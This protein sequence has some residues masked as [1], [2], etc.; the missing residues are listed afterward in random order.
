MKLEDTTAFH[1]LSNQD[2][3]FLQQAKR[4]I[5]ITGADG[6]PAGRRH[7]YICPK[8]GNGSGR[9]G[10]GMAPHDC[11]GHERWHCFKCGYDADIIGLY[12]D[13]IGES[14][15]LKA[16]RKL[17]DAYGIQVDADWH[18]GQKHER[19]PLDWDAEIGGGESGSCGNSAGQDEH[20]HGNGT[21][22]HS[23][24]NGTSTSTEGGQP[25]TSPAGA[26]SPAAAPDYSA[27]YADCASH[28]AE[29]SYLQSRGIS[30]PTARRLGVGYDPHCTSVPGI[31]GRPAIIFPASRSVMSARICDLNMNSHQGSRKKGSPDVSFN[32]QALQDAMIGGGAVWITEGEID[33]MS[34]EELGHHAVGIKGTPRAPAFLQELF[35]S[36]IRMP[37]IIATDDDDPGR[38]AAGVLAEGLARAQIP[39]Y[40][41]P[42]GWSNGAK[43]PNGMLTADRDALAEL[44]DDAEREARD[45]AAK[46]HA[47]QDQEQAQKA[48]DDAAKADEAK[49]QQEQEQANAIAEEEKRRQRHLA[50]P[51]AYR[52]K[53]EAIRSDRTPRIAT[54]FKILDEVLDGGLKP[55]SLYTVGAIS[56]LGKTTFCTQIGDYIAEHGTDVLIFSLEMARSELISKSVSRLTARIQQQGNPRACFYSIPAT[57]CAEWSN[58]QSYIMKQAKDQKRNPDDVAREVNSL[59]ARAEDA[60]WNPSAGAA[61]RTWIY[62]SSGDATVDD[63][64]TAIYD[65]WKYTGHVPVVFIDYLQ[66]LHQADD[67]EHPH[68]SR[69]DKQVVDYNISELKR[70]CR[71]SP[72]WRIDSTARPPVPIIAISS[73]NRI[74]YEARITMSALKESGSVEF[75]SDVIIGLQLTGAGKKGFNSDL[76]KRKSPRN[77][78]C[79]IL[80]NRLGETDGI[81]FAYFTKQNQFR[82]D[83]R[84]RSDEAFG[85]PLEDGTKKQAKDGGT[86]EMNK[87]MAMFSKMMKQAMSGNS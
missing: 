7:S 15:R 28:I 4:D 30:I 50:Y 19:E 34:M 62:E 83:S 24:A 60:Y 8:C 63:I 18:G 5:T 31:C 37:C 67:P 51:L 38:G 33:A 82:E 48:A 14:D 2:P 52:E 66:I 71:G 79:I 40:L 45:V 78:D 76:E 65:H 74:N 85:F 73:V 13:S 29:Q 9:N 21:A 87:F 11:A 26:A 75:S 80:K 86:S 10:T 32:L 44:A 53:Y 77:V 70:I 12:A 41:L 58:R 54:G 55:G 23:T 20:H 42:N 36:G 16:F 57:A 17:C 68:A 49:R 22:D 61:A 6:Q 56:S 35:A 47:K 1:A 69:T 59:I 46:L 39:F 3:T 84:M 64:R 25:F 81:H 43:D 72:N 27:Y